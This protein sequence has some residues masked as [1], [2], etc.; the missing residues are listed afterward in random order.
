M[1]L[2]G[3][4]VG[5][6][7]RCLLDRMCRM[8]QARRFSCIGWISTRPSFSNSFQI[9]LPF[10]VRSTTMVQPRVPTPPQAMSAS[11]AEKSAQCW[12]SGRW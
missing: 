4:M 7:L 10:S 8:F 2:L 1:P 3:P 11:S 6:R 12:H 5:T 9:S